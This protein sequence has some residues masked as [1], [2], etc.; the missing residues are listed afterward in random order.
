MK[1][2]IDSISKLSLFSGIKKEDLTTMLTCLG[3]YIHD[4]KK[5]EFISLSSEPVQSIGVVLQGTIHMI[6]EDV[7]GNKTIL[8]FIKKD[9]VFGET[10]VC[11]NQSNSMVTFYSSTNSKILYM[12]F[13]K[14]IHSCTMSCIFHHRLIENM[15]KLMA[16]KNAQ[17]MEKIEII[18]KKTIRKKILT[19]M[20]LQSQIHE[21]DY[22]EIPLGRL[23]LADYLCVDRSALTREL[24]NMKKDKIITFTKNSFHILKK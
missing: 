7:W 10:F 22:F 3:S 19:Y 1:D 15:M 16:N 17:L 18:S 21:S 14:V 5:G 6:K 2:Y 13:Y 23:E 9:E 8:A 20:L 4:Y 24:N 11:G 12:P